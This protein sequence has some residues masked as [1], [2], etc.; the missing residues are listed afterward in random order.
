LRNY[1]KQSLNLLRH[2]LDKTPRIMKNWK[3][4][5]LFL[6]FTI[7]L[8][9][10]SPSVPPTLIYPTAVEEFE[11]EILFEMTPFPTRPAY[12]PGE[13]VDYVAQ[14]GDTLPALAARFNT[15]IDEIRRANPII[16]DDATTMP[17]GM[18]M[19]IPIYYRPLWGTPFQI[20]PDAVFVN[21]PDAASFDASAYIAQS[22]GWIN[23][24]EAWAFNGTRTAG[25]IVDYVGLNYSVSPKVQLA[26]LE[27]IAGAFSQPNLTPSA[28]RNV[29]G[30]STNYWT[31]VYLQLSHASNL[32]N[33]SYYRWRSGD[34]LEFELVDGSLVRPDPWQNAASV[35]LQHF[36]SQIMGVQEFHRAIGP[37]GFSLT[38]QTLFGDPWIVEP[39]IPGTLRQPEMLL[40][41][42]TDK[43][44]A[45]TGGPHTGWGSLEPWAALD[46]APPS[47]VSGCF[48][49]TVHTTAVADGLVVRDDTG[50]LI[51]DLDGDGDER[52]GWAVLYLHIANEGR[53]PMGTYV[54][55]G[56]PLGFPSC[57][58]GRSTGTHI[59][60]ARKYNGEWI[61]ADG[62]VAFVLSG[63]QPIRGEAPYKGWLVK[64]G[65][66]V[67]ASD[68]PDGRSMIPLDARPGD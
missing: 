22:D 12:E 20:I 66:M 55:A 54:Q 45:Y 24:Y 46:F 35:A 2:N 15:T 5:A 41:F 43:I 56:D 52:T 50:L 21:G 31:G 57:E 17:P 32:L 4:Y 11:G 6:I 61:E 47:T 30:L 25:E 62:P 40:P 58:G 60:I 48:P 38:Y 59:H 19:Q 9:A 7:I 14:T 23:S 63:W 13:L 42:A 53:V 3:N 64:D 33:D 28:E 26:L 34:L 27:Y 18:P 49:S 10:C 68:N 67:L 65:V 51:L 39:H 1:C 44:W 37:E 29:L 16:P 8:A 36:F